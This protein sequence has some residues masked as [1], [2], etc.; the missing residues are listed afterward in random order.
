ML[1]VGKHELITENAKYTGHVDEYDQG[2]HSVRF[3]FYVRLHVYVLEKY[4]LLELL[5]PETN[6]SHHYLLALS[7]MVF[8]DILINLYHA[9]GDFSHQNL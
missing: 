7:G 6:Y 9:E 3:R 2:R 1:V 8:C 5:L 4:H